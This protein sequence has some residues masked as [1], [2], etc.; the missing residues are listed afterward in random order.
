MS[1]R[2]VYLWAPWC[3]ECRAMTPRIEKLAAEHDPSVVVQKISVA[4]SPDAAARLGV[5]G[6]PT[7][8]GFHDDVELF[9]V[10]GR[11]TPT[12]LEE[13]FSAAAAGSARI[14]VG[15]TDRVLRVGA[16]AALTI[17]GALLGPA[18]PLVGVGAGIA[19]WGAAGSPR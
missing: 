13:L 7:I 15:R 4:E 5:M 18:W 16:G 3:M 2:I 17:V 12:E 6:T 8:I 14:T 10:S 9:R 11:R 1:R 19:V